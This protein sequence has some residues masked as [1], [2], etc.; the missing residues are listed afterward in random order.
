MAEALAG[1]IYVFQAIIII[2]III[3]IGL[4]CTAVCCAQRVIYTLS[5]VQRPQHHNT[6][7]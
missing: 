7:L 5:A 6:N 4:L 1:K 2:V 3:K